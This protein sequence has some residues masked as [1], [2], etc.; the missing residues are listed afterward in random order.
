VLFEL[1]SSSAPFLLQSLRGCSPGL[2]AL[3]RASVFL[4]RTA[5]L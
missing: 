4:L 1:I 2:A 3:G 5:G